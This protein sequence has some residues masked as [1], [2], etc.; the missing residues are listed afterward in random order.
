MTISDS[1]RQLL[2]SMLRYE[3]DNHVSVQLKTRGDYKSDEYRQL[4]DAS[5]YLSKRIKELS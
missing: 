4:L 2:Q 1:H 5:E 3:L